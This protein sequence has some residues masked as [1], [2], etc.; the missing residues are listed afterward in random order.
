MFAMRK[1]ALKALPLVVVLWAAFVILGGA[2]RLVE[3]TEPPE[4]SLT[5]TVVGFCAA[6]VAL[7][8]GAYGVRAAARGPGFFIKS[9]LAK[10]SSPWTVPAPAAYG[11]PPPPGPP[12]LHLLQILRT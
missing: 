1:A 10:I 12:L 9:T 8:A 11:Q 7:A 6:F 2:V 5:K 3:K 4:D